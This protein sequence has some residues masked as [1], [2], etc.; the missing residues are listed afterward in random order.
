MTAPSSIVRQICPDLSEDEISRLNRIEYL[1]IVC[2]SMLLKQPISPYYVTNI[3]DTWVPMTAVIEMSNIVDRQELGGQSLVYLPKYLPA[4]H[5]DFEKSDEQFQESF[6]SALENMYPE[7]SRDQVIDFKICRTRNVMAIPTI[8]YSEL[9][10]D[11][12]TSVPGMYLINSSYILKGNLNVNETIEIA[13][14][15]Y[16]D[17]ISQD[18]GVTA[19]TKDSSTVAV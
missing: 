12:K 10:P 1:G 11:Q 9:L 5:P 19:Q 8:Q 13:E 16:R 3:T 15:A 2:A 14:T 6:L 4:D 18:T 7:F 17:V